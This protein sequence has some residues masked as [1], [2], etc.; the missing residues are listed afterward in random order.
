MSSLNLQQATSTSL[1]QQKKA[2][3]QSSQYGA[4]AHAAAPLTAPTPT[5]ASIPPAGMWTPEV[6]IRFGGV[7]TSSGNAR[8]SNG[9]PQDGRW[10][11]TQGLKFG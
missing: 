10:D 6:G 1:Q 4:S 7:P 3:A 11:P 9:P 8:P 5:R 2:D